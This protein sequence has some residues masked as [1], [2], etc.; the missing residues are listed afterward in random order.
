MAQR[1]VKRDLFPPWLPFANTPS[2]FPISTLSVWF[3]NHRF[4]FSASGGRARTHQVNKNGT[5]QLVNGRY[6]PFERRSPSAGKCVNRPEL[7]V[8]LLFPPLPFPMAPLW[9]HTSSRFL[10]PPDTLSR[11]VKRLRSR[12]MFAALPP[13]PHSVRNR[14][15]VCRGEAPEC[16]PLPMC[17]LREAL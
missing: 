5:C 6:L 14:E 8:N 4:L 13:R 12:H 3:F 2:S 15:A 11:S 17:K 16:F 10:H 7:K 9:F 1:A